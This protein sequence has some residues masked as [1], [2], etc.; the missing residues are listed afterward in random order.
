[1]GPYGHFPAA[2]LDDAHDGRSRLLRWHEV[3]DGERTRSSLEHGFEHYRIFQVRARNLGGFGGGAY[4]PMTVFCMAEQRGETGAAVEA[5]PTQPIDAAIQSHQRRC[6]AIADNC[7]VLNRQGIVG[8]SRNFFCICIYDNRYLAS[9]DRCH[10]SIFDSR[11]ARA[12][13]LPTA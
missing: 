5:W 8:I 9:V 12:I 6:R 7:I 2:S 1:M 13:A 10:L 11:R 4:R 3:D